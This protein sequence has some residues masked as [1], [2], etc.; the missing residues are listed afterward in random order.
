[1]KRN[2]QGRR[3][4]LRTDLRKR[5]GDH[6]C[7]CGCEMDFGVFNTAKP[8][9]DNAP[10][11]LATIEHFHTPFSIGGAWTLDN[12]KLACRACNQRLG[13]IWWRYR[14][15]ETNLIRGAWPVKA[16]PALFESMAA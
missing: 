1:M 5:D 3:R 16:W 15:A 9:S 14:T 11:S 8:G 10:L 4:H 2:W 13:R 7:H 12:C 6:C